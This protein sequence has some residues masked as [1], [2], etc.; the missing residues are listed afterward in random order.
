M[1][2]RICKFYM[3]THQFDCFFVKDPSWALHFCKGL[4]HSFCRNYGNEDHNK[5][6]VHPRSTLE[7]LVHY[8]R[9]VIEYWKTRLTSMCPRLNHIFVK[10]GPAP[11]TPSSLS[12]LPVRTCVGTLSCWEPMWQYPITWAI[13]RHGHLSHWTLLAYEGTPSIYLGIINMMSTWISIILTEYCHIGRVPRQVQARRSCNERG[14]GRA[15]PIR[16]SLGP[17]TLT[18][19]ELS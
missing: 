19:L 13:K 7:S 4:V 2:S 18:I 11:P 6:G 17:S 9:I 8:F 10:L 5:H 15:G 14:M 3:K 12:N 1:A 16:F